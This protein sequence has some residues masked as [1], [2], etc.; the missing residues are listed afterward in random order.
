MSTI[1]ELAAASERIGNP[2]VQTWFH[3]QSSTA[4]HCI[5]DP[6]THHCALIDSVLD[7]DYAAGHTRTQF[8]DRIITFI[9]TEGLK[10]DWLLETHAHADHLSAAGYLR[11]KLGGRIA[12]GEHIRD[13]QKVFRALFHDERIAQD[14]RPFDKLFADGE[15]VAIGELQARVMH[16]PGHTP[17]CVVYVVGDCA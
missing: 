16:T 13:V 9:K 15:T 6:A 7:F 2:V 5:I 4:C 12:I 14:G 10:L 1:A 8:A 11:D 3:Q 17:A